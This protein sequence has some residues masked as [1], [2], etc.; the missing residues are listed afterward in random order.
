MNKKDIRLDLL[1]KIEFKPQYTQR[2]LS[3][4]MGVSLGKVNYCIKKLA[5]KGLIKITNFKH[6]PNKVEYLY[7]LTPKGIEMKASLTYS[8]LKIKIEEYQ[9]LK[10]EITKLKEDVEK[11]GYQESFK[12]N[13]IY[14]LK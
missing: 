7:L 1:R 13:D 2:E 3:K 9:T 8:F 10:E 14:G 6:N 11:L 12:I 5:E 4:E